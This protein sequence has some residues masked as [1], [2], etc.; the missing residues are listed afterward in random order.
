VPEAE[1]RISRDEPEPIFELAQEPARQ[2]EALTPS[3]ES[4]EAAAEPSAVSSAPYQS[5]PASPASVEKAIEEV[6]AVID[7]LRSALEDMDEL[8][9]MLEMF[10]RQKN[11]D[12]REIDSLRRALRQMHRPRDAGHH[13]HR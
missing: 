13:P 1:P 5:Q 10:E 3:G 8:L 6:S 2:V 12:E 4:S 7:T 11:A 9:E